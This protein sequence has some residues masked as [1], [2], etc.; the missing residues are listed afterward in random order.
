ME[1]A[2][3][4]QDELDRARL[5]AIVNSCPD[6]IIGETLDGIITDWNPAAERVYGYS[7]ADAIGQSIVL[8]SP[9]DR[10][11]E[12]RYLL[13]QVRQGTSVEGF[14]TVRRT[15]DGRLIDVSLTVFPI[16]D[17]Q[18][19]VVGAS[20]TTRDISG[21]K[22]AESALVE[23]RHQA[24]HILE[25]ISDGFLTL[26]RT[27][28]ITYLNAAAET[29]LACNRQVV[30]QTSIWRAL[31]LEEA[32]PFAAACR[33]ALLSGTT[34]RIEFFH[35][36]GERWLE[37]RIDPFEEGLAIF[38]RDVTDAHTLSQELHASEAKYRALVEHL[39]AAVYLLAADENETPLYYSPYIEQLRGVSAEEVIK[40]REEHWLAF[41]HPDDIE[42]VATANERAMAADGHFRAEYRTLRADGSYVW[43]LDECV[44]IHDASGA[45][46]A[47]QG[48]LMDITARIEADAVRA[49]LAA[50]VEGA[51]DA[52]FSRTLDGT[53]TSWNEGA[54]HLFGWTAEE[55]IGQSYLKLIPG[56]QVIEQEPC[57]RR[58]D[59]VQ[60]A[61]KPRA[62]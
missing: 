54:E 34:A 57:W 26:D 40:A 12:V 53:I 7:A 23:A 2:Q 21:R 13:N 39:P 37:A 14:E 55:M 15:R 44:P 38:L 35:A 10:S 43:V 8:I 48:I 33:Q 22:A 45:V 20:A 56:G 6:P 29:I 17:E 58:L 25:L 5:A 42:R 30:L 24:Q 62:G 51:E 61:S 32:S 41:L 16:R 52:I 27:W 3:A 1:S 59:K 18:G 9:P 46:L 47:W 28:R 36:P 60:R 49:R 50:I 31:E 11:D 19:T 4:R